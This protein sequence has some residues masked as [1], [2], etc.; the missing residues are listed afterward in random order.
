MYII[1]KY[2]RDWTFSNTRWQHHTIYFEIS[3]NYTFHAVTGVGSQWVRRGRRCKQ[4]AGGGE[5]GTTAERYCDWHNDRIHHVSTVHFANLYS[6]WAAAVAA[7]AN[8][9]LPNKTN[10]SVVRCTAVT[11]NQLETRLSKAQYTFKTNTT[12]KSSD[13]IGA[14]PYDWRI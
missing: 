10:E 2:S 6:A 9:S 8:N 4:A 1:L 12:K 7:T 13:M 14:R 11:V 5:R 3:L